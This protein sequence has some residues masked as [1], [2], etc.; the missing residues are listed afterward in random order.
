M[1]TIRIILSVAF[2]FILVGLLSCESDD[3][4]CVI[5]NTPA[6]SGKLLD[7][8]QCKSNTDKKTTFADNFTAIE[9]S[10]NSTTKIL[11][12]KQINAAFNCCPD[13]INGQISEKNGII[14]VKAVEKSNAC[15]CSCLYD[16]SFELKNIE[17]KTYEIEIVEQ[18]F[19]ADQSPIKITVDFD[20]Q[21]EGYYTYDRNTYPWGIYSQ[22]ATSKLISYSG[23][24]NTGK[25][26]LAQN[27]EECIRYTINDD[28]DVV[29]LHI[30]AAF[31]CCP[32]EIIAD[33]STN[34]QEIIINEASTEQGCKC[35]CL[36]DIE[37]LLTNLEAGVY[38][39]IIKNSLTNN[40]K[41]IN[42]VMDLT[43]PSGEDC[44][45]RGYYPWEENGN[46]IPIDQSQQNSSK[47]FDFKDFHH[48]DYK[49]ISQRIENDCLKID[50]EYSGGCEDHEFVL[51][52]IYSMS[53]TK[54][55]VLFLSHNANGDACEAYLTETLSFDLSSLQETGKNETSI[56]VIYLD[57]KVEMKYN[58]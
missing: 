32:G 43:K 58:Y 28:G 11:A 5:E 13:E 26:T 2:S 57:D 53:S 34:G 30:N 39:V 55:P 14:T 27:T 15:D 48:D 52:Q 10:Y 7:F 44:I 3:C 38:N 46:C 29:F 40:E 20:K 17:P 19:P 18:Y 16:L 33:I 4:N 49:V 45:M 25:S 1:K 23:C 47:L 54:D 22:E 31:N 9:F 8:G 56:L 6:I 42:Y 24:K 35:N 12:L 41:D 50:V 36:Y 51:Y 37:Y 21:T